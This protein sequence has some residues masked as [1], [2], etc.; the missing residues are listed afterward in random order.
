MS[1]TDPGGGSDGP[2]LP[3]DILRE[4]TDEVEASRA[5]LLDHLTELRSRLLWSFLA[6]L[7]GFV[8]C[9]AVSK[10]IYNILV[11]PYVDAVGDA[12]NGR[13]AE[14]W[15]APLEFFFTRI[16]LGLMAGFVLVFPF[17]AYQLYAFVS[18]GLYR[19]EKRAVLPFLV[20]MPVLFSAGAAIVY[21]LIMPFIMTFAVGMEQ[22]AAE[23]TGATIRIFTK[24][25][26]YLSLITSLIMGFGFAFQMPVILVLLAMAGIISD[27]FL[28]KNRPFAIVGVFFL[29]AVLTPPDPASQ[30]ILGTM[31]Y[32]LY[33]ISIIAVRLAGRHERKQNQPAAAE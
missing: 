3:P 22:Q 26:E 5:P 18:P 20:A 15:F 25:G 11:I 27:K 9:F 14:L 24:V 32:G 23:G 30:I 19:N 28:A 4:E 17:M 31:M 29:A 1:V 6:L 33:E 16:K 21:F 7:V 12:E 8:L 2:D 13:Q 10:Q